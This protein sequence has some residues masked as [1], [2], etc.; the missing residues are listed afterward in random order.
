MIMEQG[1]YDGNIYIEK[2][3]QCKIIYSSYPMTTKLYYT[4]TCI[5]WRLNLVKVFK[6]MEAQYIKKEEHVLTFITQ[7]SHSHFALRQYSL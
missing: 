3:F 1:D 2:Q 5:C 6:T 4:I 7:L